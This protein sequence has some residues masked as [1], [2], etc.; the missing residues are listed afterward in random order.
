MLK[1]LG[2][3]KV[4]TR[5]GD[6]HTGRSAGSPFLIASSTSSVVYESDRSLL[7]REM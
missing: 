5:H 2:R 1:I 4:E 7:G 6:V 3:E